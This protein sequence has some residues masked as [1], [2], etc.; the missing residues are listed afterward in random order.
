MSLGTVFYTFPGEAS[1]EWC[2]TGFASVPC[3]CGGMP[4]RGGRSSHFRPLG[5]PLYTHL[6]VVPL[7][8]RQQPHPNVSPHP[9]SLPLTK[10]CIVLEPEVFSCA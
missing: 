9:D 2:L 1:P 6:G 5:D 10:F 3:S 7:K 4:Y 8:P